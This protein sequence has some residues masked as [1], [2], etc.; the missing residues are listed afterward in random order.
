ME[1]LFNDKKLNIIDKLEFIEAFSNQCIGEV[2]KD[3][4]RLVREEL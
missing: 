1:Y 2:S 4:V 3:K